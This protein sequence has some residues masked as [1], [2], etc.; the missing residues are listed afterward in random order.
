MR[1]QYEISTSES[2]VEYIASQL[3]GQD[4]LSTLQEHNNLIQTNEKEI[5]ERRN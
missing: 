4:C 5:A 3:G 1:K 2:V